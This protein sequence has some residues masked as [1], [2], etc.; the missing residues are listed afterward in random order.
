M[1]KKIDTEQ[2]L[3]QAYKSPYTGEFYAQTNKRGFVKHLNSEL[4]LREEQEAMRN[5]GQRRKQAWAHIRETATCIEDVST[6]LKTLPREVTEHYTKRAFMR[7][8]N[9][10]QFVLTLERHSQPSHVSI[11]HDS[12]LNENTNWGGN[13]K[14]RAVSMLGI[15]GTAKENLNYGFSEAK[16]ESGIATCN[17]EFILFAEDWPFVAKWALKAAFSGNLPQ[18]SD[19]HNPNSKKYFEDLETFSQAH[20]GM[21]YASLCGLRDSLGLTAT[22]LNKMMADH[23]LGLASPALDSLALP[24]TIGDDTMMGL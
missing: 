7:V 20:V 19:H 9:D 24:D 15:R 17:S 14:N 18:P 2:Y 4:K 6:L 10:F 3:T 13:D 16:H 12:P 1:A 8:P 11:T 23:A 22:D 5:A 21:S